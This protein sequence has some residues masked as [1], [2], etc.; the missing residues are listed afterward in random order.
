M[1]YELTQSPRLYIIEGLITVGWAFCCIFLVPKNYETAYFLNDAD[2]S[3]MRQRAEEMEAYSGS[4]GHYGMKDVKEAAKDIKSWIHGLIQIAVVTILYGKISH[5]SI[6]TSMPLTGCDL[7]FGTFLPIIIK[8]G[9]KFST[10]QAQYLV[11]PVNLWGAAVYAVG[12]I[13]S[14]RYTARFLPLIICAPF[15]IVGYA[16]LLAPVPTS[17]H[18]FGTFLIATACFLCTGGNM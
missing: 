4:S 7:G 16:I 13:L 3:I 18:Y 9:F 15:G 1:R 2:K 11:I 10:V 8:D 17:V 14:D 6:S 5:S 12:A